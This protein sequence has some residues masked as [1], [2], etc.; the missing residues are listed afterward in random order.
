MLKIAGDER[1]SACPATA[2][3]PRDACFR[4]PIPRRPH[5]LCR[6]VQAWTITPPGLWQRRIFLRLNRGKNMQSLVALVATSCPLLRASG[7]TH[8]E[9]GFTASLHVI[10]PSELSASHAPKKI[11]APKKPMRPR[12]PCA[13]EKCPGAGLPGHS[14]E[15][16]HGE[17]PR[18]H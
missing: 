14:K 5:L 7:V 9:R 2:P 11:K 12:K 13:Q 4:R 3:P 16:V 6:R 15:G 17:H 18:T 1:P 8:V 10:R